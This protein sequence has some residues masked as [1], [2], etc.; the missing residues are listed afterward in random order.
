MSISPKPR[1][2]IVQPWFTAHGHP[3]QT[4]INTARM[5]G[6]ILDV[7]YVI[8]K[9][10]NSDCFQ[11]MADSL[12]AIA[13]VESFKVTSNSIRI[14]TF[15]ALWHLAKMSL[16]GINAECIFFLDAHLIVLAS[17]WF[18]FNWIIRPRRM[19]LLYLQGPER[20]HRY[21]LIRKLVSWFLCRKEVML[22]LRTSELRDAWHAN[23]PEV[24]PERIGVLPSL[25][26][27]D[28]LCIPAPLSPAPFQ[29]LGVIGQIRLG[30]GLERL[31]PLFSAHPELGVLTVAGA[32]SEQ[33][34]RDALPGLKDYPHFID[35]FLSEDEINKIASKQDYLLMLYENWD[36][37][38]ESATLY[39]AARANRPV[40]VYEQGWCGRM[41]K[42]YGCGVIAPNSCERLAEFIKDL[43]KNGTPAYNALLSGI[44]EFRKAHSG[45]AV[46][47]LFIRQIFETE[48]NNVS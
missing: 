23:F 4:T 8:S 31:L 5:L 17:I 47:N 21:F 16:R 26:L 45:D 1:L 12:R 37:R 39:L 20:A 25:E 44:E 27:P 22:F 36:A 34:Q 9:E 41:V 10:T 29:R 6:E 18:L 7:T 46:R 40:I 48:E 33:S 19:P 15:A 42:T 14:G 38:M 24:P 30:K 2:F 43:P 35:R 13:T 3:A 11:S 32:F 28:T